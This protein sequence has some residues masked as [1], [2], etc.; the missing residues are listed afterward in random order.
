MENLNESQNFRVFFDEDSTQARSAE[1]HIENYT[2]EAQRLLIGRKLQTKENAMA[3][4][5][6]FNHVK[7]LAFTDK[8]LSEGKIWNPNKPLV[9]P[10]PV[11][12][13]HFMSVDDVSTNLKTSAEL[14]TS[15]LEPEPVTKIEKMMPSKSGLKKKQDFLFYEMFAAYTKKMATH[16]K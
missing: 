10:R 15:P 7:R 11:K 3:F 8:L 12:E 6:N 4:V 16:K 2:K 14:L 5:D 9:K 1:E 13:D